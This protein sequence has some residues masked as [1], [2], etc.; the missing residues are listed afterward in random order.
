MATLNFNETVEEASNSKKS[1]KKE[2]T[3]SQ[4]SVIGVN[5]EDSFKFFAKVFL[6]KQKRD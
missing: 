6:E 3:D 5:V 4:S 2:K 1:R